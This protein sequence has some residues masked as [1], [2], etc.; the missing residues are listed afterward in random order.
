M[1]I[2][3][4]FIYLYIVCI[5]SYFNPSLILKEEEECIIFIFRHFYLQTHNDKKTLI[6]L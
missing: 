1:T 6:N 3:F 2:H 4:G 5:H